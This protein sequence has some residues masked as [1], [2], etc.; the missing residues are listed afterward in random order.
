MKRRV[1]IM[2][3]LSGIILLG[4]VMKSQAADKK[5]CLVLAEGYVSEYIGGEYHEGGPSE[6]PGDEYYVR[7]VLEYASRFNRWL[8]GW[9]VQWIDLERQKGPLKLDGVDLVILD[10][11][12]QSVCGPYEQDL[13]Q[14]VKQGGGLLVYGGAWGLGGRPK[15]NLSVTKEISSY[16][17]SSLAA[18]LP[19]EIIAT[20]DLTKAEH[21]PMFV[22]PAVGA[23]IQ[24]P[25]WTVFG[26][27]ACKNRG[28][29]VAELDGKPFIAWHQ[30][31]K[32]RVVVY[33]GDDLAW[34]RSRKGLNVNPFAG[35]LWR[36]L[37][38]LATGATAEIPA[39]ADPAITWEKSPVFAHPDQQVN[40]MWGDAN[41]MNLETARDLVT[42]SSTLIVFGSP[43]PAVVKA[44]IQ[45]TRSFGYPLDVGASTNT[46]ESMWMVDAKGKRFVTGPWSLKFLCYNNPKALQRIDE[47]MAKSA[48]A[49][50]NSYFT[51]GHMGDEPEYA[52][53]YCEYCRAK[54]RKEFGYNMPVEKDDFSP[55]FLDKWIDYLIFK[56]RSI[57]E[58]YARMAKVVKQNNPNMK[59]MFASVPQ[60][61]TMS[62]G[63]DQFNTQSGFDLLW[64]HTY[65]GSQPIIVGLN[66][67]LMEETAV[68]QGRPYV[69]ALDL[70]QGFDYY[71]N[72]PYMPPAE[73]VREM[74]WQAI[75]HGIDSVGWF[76]YNYGFW[77][78]PSTEAWEEIGR[79]GRDVLA[80][81]T[82]TLYRMTNVAQPVGLVYCYSQEAVDG[83]KE[84]VWDK[85][86][87]WQCLIRWWSHHATQEAYDVLKYAHVPVNMVSEYRIMQGKD[88]PWKVLVI[89]YV[90]H[91]QKDTR[92]ALEKFIARGGTVYIGSNSTLEM[93]GVKKLPFAFDVKFNTWWPED[94]K[95][96]WNQRRVRAYTIT[97]S[98]E[99]ARE[100][101]SLL[102]PFCDAAPV[103]VDDPEV[104]W[105]MREAGE[106]KYFFFV[107]DHQINPMSAEL[108]KERT[109]HPHFYISP[110][111]FPAVETSVR[112]MGAGTLYPLLDPANTALRQMTPKG[113]TMKL[114]LK[115]GEGKVFV[116]LPEPVGKVEF[117]AEPTRTPQGVEVK[118]RVLGNK[119]A[120]R[121]S[122]PIRVDLQ[123][124]GI[125]Q[126]AYT[127]TREGLVEWTVPFLKDM[128]AGPM[129]VTVTELASGKSANQEIR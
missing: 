17:R 9:T 42:H 120:I 88:L 122:L 107:N 127:T 13:I 57:G 121:A 25:D 129:K 44:G 66:A 78:M 112:L 5:T 111:E 56:N 18:I 50:T 70:L 34:I 36:R 86:R 21:K 92:K 61:V 85:K 94:R 54:F 35:T 8:E 40:F 3:V 45:V 15:T 114:S 101:R 30:V 87:P 67:Q 116:M 43:S 58:M 100:M 80:P 82:P 4:G 32:G 97:N 55:E 41:M 74:V 47:N 90:E 118:A 59:A 99:K 26:F 7:G 89:A 69:P 95:E 117:T 123:S 12:R 37:A 77:R 19:V 60:G 108:R 27:H 72:V 75:A 76:V 83:L 125:S 2:S 38:A 84:L 52:N 23:G 63:D 14:F 65:P 48:V 29:A 115:G 128:P 46:D 62:H 105:N 51:H 126:I 11:V 109:K 93:P 79:L 124:G 28:T 106:A 96:E 113:L 68:L 119:A 104:V 24:A 10:D 49:Q 31:G 64:D 53:C 71:N 81:L 33:T 73:Y 6:H 103:Q 16:Q 102:A 22:D 91:L 39:T 20:P 110:A 98:L 1:A